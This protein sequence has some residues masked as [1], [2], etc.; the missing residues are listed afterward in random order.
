VVLPAICRAPSYKRS[1]RAVRP[2][3]KRFQER[4]SD[5]LK[6]WK[7]SPIDETAR[8]HY[9]DYTAARH[10]MLRATHTKDAPWTLVD[11]NDQKVGR[12][13]LI[14]NLLDRLP[15]VQPTDSKVDLPLLDHKP[16][17]EEFAKLQ[18]IKPFGGRKD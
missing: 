9:A 18:P 7:L 15:E 10:E 1:D 16:L 8:L 2:Q 11:F 17:A 5:P 3:E 6:Q 12:L 14:R 13:T 4:L